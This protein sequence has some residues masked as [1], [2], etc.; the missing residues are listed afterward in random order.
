[1]PTNSGK[2]FEMYT[3]CAHVSKHGSS[4]Q[5]GHVG[6]DFVMMGYVNQSR[7]RDIPTHLCTAR[8]IQYKD[9]Q[10]ATSSDSAVVTAAEAPTQ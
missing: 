2:G 1:M 5:C 7:K 9:T 8:D 4:A 3:A 6:Q 10:P